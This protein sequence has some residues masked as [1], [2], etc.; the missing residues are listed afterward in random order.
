MQRE[1]NKSEWYPVQ[2]ASQS[3][4]PS[5]RN[6]SSI[7]R[8]SLSVVFG[9]ERFKKF[10][11]G[12]VFTIHNDH[13][14]SRKLLAHGSAIPT[15]CSARLQ[16]WALCLSQFKYNL[17]YSKGINNVHSDFLSG[18]PLSDTEK[19]TEPYE[20]VFVIDKLD[21]MP[22]NCSNV[23]RYTDVDNDLVEL[24]QFIKFGVPNK[25]TNPKLLPFKS[26]TTELSILKGCI[27]YRNNVVIPETLRAK[28]L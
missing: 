12:T 7:E 13:K 28:M 25:L 1:N 17:E 10:L 22:I 14:P 11:L 3:L 23:Q 19:K 8:N 24:K 4:H 20:L 18:F 2:L 16:R 15:T 21:K 5:E 27:L 9:Y 26:I 6:Y